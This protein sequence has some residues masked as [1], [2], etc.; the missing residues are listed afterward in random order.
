MTIPAAAYE[1]T[2][3]EVED[4]IAAGVAW[5]ATQQNA[6]DGYWG[7]YDRVGHTGFVLT[8]LLDR[9]YETEPY[10]PFDE[11]YEYNDNVVSGLTWLLQWPNAQLKGPGICFY[12]GGHETYSTG[13]AMMALAAT[14]T[15]NAVIV[16]TNS[17]VNGLTYL[18]LLQKCVDYFA[19]AQNP[20]GGWRYIADPQP[21]DNSTTGYALLGLRYAEEFGCVIPQSL[22]DNLSGFI[23]AIQNDVGVGDPY[24]DGGSSYTINGGWEN[25]LKTGNLLFEMAFVGDTTATPRVQDAIDFIE[26]HWNS[27]DDQLGWK[28]NFQGMYCLMK[29]FASLGIETVNVGSVDIDWYDVISDYIIDDPVYKQRPEGFW[30]TTV[31]GNPILSTCWALLT[32][33]KIAPP[34][35]NEPPTVWCD[36]GTNPHGNVVPGK[37]RGKNGKDLPNRNPDGFYVL[38]A[39][40]DNTPVEEIQIYVGLA[41]YDPENGIF[42][43]YWAMGWDPGTPEIPPTV[44]L[45]SGDQIKVT[46]APGLEPSYK[47]IGS[48]A[49]GGA[50]AVT[51]H[52]TVPT[53]QDLVIVAIDEHGAMAITQCPIVPPPPM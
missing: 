16:S 36:E 32:L 11:A 47:K 10:D 12:P 22:K 27:N 41:N 40:D 34:P 5:L 26:R 49:K 51:W 9:G 1:R 14:R 48:P 30:P 28:R 23:D 43:P 13:I 33:E 38:Y 6:T 2:D 53:D 39:E 44:V 19:W 18:Q 37:N 17:V 50:T 45:H 15:P 8:K 52:I 21:S 7:G 25:I 46:E 24:Y 42:E 20:D 3:D 31:W 29:G 35:P 4:A